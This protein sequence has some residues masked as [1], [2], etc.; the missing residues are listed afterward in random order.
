MIWPAPKDDDSWFIKTVKDI[1]RDGW[2]AVPII[3]VLVIGRIAG[4]W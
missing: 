4:W 2:F 3:A 1:V